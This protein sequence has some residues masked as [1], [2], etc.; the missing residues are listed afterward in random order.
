MAGASARVARS[1]PVQLD[2]AKQGEVSLL[3]QLY[4]PIDVGSSTYTLSSETIFIPGRRIRV[5]DVGLD[6]VVRPAWAITAAATRPRRHT[7]AD[8]PVAPLAPFRFRLEGEGR[9][10]PGGAKTNGLLEIRAEMPTMDDSWDVAEV[11]QYRTY[12][13]KEQWLVKWKGYGE[14]HNSWEPKENFLQDWVLKQADEVKARAL[15][16]HSRTGR[17]V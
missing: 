12:Y 16:H 8:I 11:V 4:E 3:V 13:R 5:I 2:L 17:W 9:T 6:A 10:H 7:T 1:L 14:D 15:E